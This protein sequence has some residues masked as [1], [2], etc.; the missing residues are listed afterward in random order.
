VKISFDP[1]KRET[2]L[3]ERGLDFADS[4]QVFAGETIDIPDLRHDYGESRTISIGYLQGRM[5]I[6]VW[7]PRGGGRHVISMRK[8]NDREKTRY[9]QRHEE[10]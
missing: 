8:A 3:R 7:T 5:V 6:V 10:G 4:A 9:G 2:T 1:V